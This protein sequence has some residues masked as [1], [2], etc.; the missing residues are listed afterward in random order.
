MHVPD[1]TQ[2]LLVSRILAYRLSPLF[3]VLQDLQLH[4]RRSQGGSLG[5]ASDQLV[6]EL[7]R[8]DLKVER[9]SAV[10]DADVEKLPQHVS[11]IILS[12]RRMTSTHSERQ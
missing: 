10:F 11:Q 3:N 9:I 4:T 12:A 6:E 7:L 8:P 5:K 1:E 2:V